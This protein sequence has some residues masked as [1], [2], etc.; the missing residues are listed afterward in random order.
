MSD[1]VAETADVSLVSGKLRRTG[2]KPADETDTSDH[3]NEIVKTNDQL[4]VANNSAS[5]LRVTLPL[6][7][8]VLLLGF[9]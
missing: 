9:M 8:P 1:E 3:R 6:L 4:L 5:M 7:V 2:T